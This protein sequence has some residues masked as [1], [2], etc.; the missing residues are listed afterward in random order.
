MQE[1]TDTA[2]LD[3]VDKNLVTNQIVLTIGYDVESLVN[4]E[5]REKYKGEISVNYYGKQVPKHA[6]GTA[7]INKFT[8][9]TKI[10]TEAVLNLYSKIVNPDLLIRRINLTINHV[11]PE[12][13][14][15]KLNQPQ[16][17]DLFTDYK[18]LEE[19]Q[20]QEQQALEKERKVQ[21]VQL[22]IKKRYGKNAIL[23]GLNF[24]DGA[25]AIERNNQIGGHKA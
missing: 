10:I 4:K 3:M 24:Q 22:E 17:L 18:A 7:N 14:A 20:R 9:S 8:S 1:M 19:Q 25:T 2:C 23:K 11:V 6:H 5:V 16:Q 21:Q 13:F 15:T 12:N